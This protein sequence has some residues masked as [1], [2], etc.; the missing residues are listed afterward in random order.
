MAFNSNKKPLSIVNDDPC[1]G[2]PFNFPQCVNCAHCDGSLCKAFNKNRLELM[3]DKET[4]LF[5]CEKFVS[6]Y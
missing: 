5:N 2:K 4:D 3:V 6:K 1:E